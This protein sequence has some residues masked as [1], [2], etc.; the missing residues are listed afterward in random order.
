MIIF[1]QLRCGRAAKTDMIVE[2]SLREILGLIMRREIRLDTPHDTVVL[3]Y[4]KA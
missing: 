2:L 4:G 1:Y 3:R